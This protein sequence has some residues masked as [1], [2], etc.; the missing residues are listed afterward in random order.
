M[1]DFNETDMGLVSDWEGI[2][3]DGASFHQDDTGQDDGAEAPGGPD[4]TGGDERLEDSETPQNEGDQPED[5]PEGDPDTGEDGQTQGEG[6]D[7]RFQLKHLDTVT[8]VD[9][10]EV[11][12]LAQKGLDYDRIRGKLETLR[13]VQEELEAL[14]LEHTKTDK[15]A[16]FVSELAKEQGLDTEA[17]IDHTKAGIL[18]EKEGIDQKTALERVRLDKERAA[19]ESQRAPEGPQAAKA[20][21]EQAI[22]AFVAENTDPKTG[23]MLVSVAEIPTSVWQDFDKSGD[24]IGAYARYEN[25]QLKQRAAE[26]EQ[27]LAAKKKNEENKQKSTN[28]RQSAGDSAA[29]SDPWLA[30]LEG[31][32]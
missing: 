26:L 22:K 16:S 14:R 19:L 21:R 24:L 2:D 11:V 23:E 6:E 1:N 12:T 13:G 29:H 32:F 15:I 9:R 31:R 30:D 27:K 7:Q 20:A 17:F 25:K 10:D 18:A 3:L 4:Q 5:D 28:S 8:S